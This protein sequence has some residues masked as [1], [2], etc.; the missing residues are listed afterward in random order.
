M[1][2]S[3]GAPFSSPPAYH[4]SQQAHAHPPRDGDA[5]RGQ[6]GVD[7]PLRRDDA[8]AP[9]GHDDRAPVLADEASQGREVR[10]VRPVR[11]AAVVV[12]QERAVLVLRPCPVFHVLIRACR[13]I[14]LQRRPPE[15][16][17]PC[18]QSAM[19]HPAEPYAFNQI[20]GRQQK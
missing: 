3:V 8:H 20:C 2:M 15:K 11:A 6:Q 17:S 10:R 5:V 12:S 9:R 7:N 13:Q 4:P 1:M 14:A 19:W 16:L 18:C